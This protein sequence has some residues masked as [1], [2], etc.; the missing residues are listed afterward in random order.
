VNLF[1]RRFEERIRG[2]LAQV[3]GVAR[4]NE[5]RR[6]WPN[7][8]SI[9]VRL[10]RPVAVVLQRDRQIP[11]TGRGVAL[12]HG[13]Y[14]RACEGLVRITG[15]KEEA[16]K[17]GQPWRSEALQDAL[18]TLLQVGPHLDRL[19][20]LLLDRIDVSAAGDPRRGV[21]LR[22]GDSTAVLWGRP[23]AAVGENPVASKIRHLEVAADHVDEVRG[24]EIDVRFAALYLRESQVE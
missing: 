14:E 11:V 15:V 8:Y 12:P 4:V 9:S 20:P 22:G 18:A 3:P 1:D 19:R 23:R 7:R 21:V 2:A 10:Y 13:P 16:P 6:H 17:A 24:L 5:V